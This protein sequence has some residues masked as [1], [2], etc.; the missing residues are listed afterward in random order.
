MKCAYKQ[1][2]TKR[3]QAR[4]EALLTYQEHRARANLFAL[5]LETA[6]DQFGFNGEQLKGLL[7][8]MFEEAGDAFEHYKDESEE[9]YDPNT[10]P[11]LLQGFIN[12]LDALEVDVRKI[13][14][15]HK[16]PT[17]DMK[18]WS[19]SRKATYAGRMEILA[20]RE[21]SYKAYM[22][23][24]MLFLYHEYEY[25]GEKLSAYYNAVLDRYYEIWSAYVVCNDGWDRNLTYLV[26]SPLARLEKI[27]IDLVGATDTDKAKKG[28]ENNEL[29]DGEKS[30]K[31]S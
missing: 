27:G 1:E 17:P 22:Y 25:E 12:Q 7:D 16:F 14:K 30:E 11:F 24:F 10:V 15:S 20:D 4:D 2:I 23:A 19:I 21:V 26:N 6:Q 29:V 28:E 13:E 18:Y 5:A 31:E 9:E 8:G 3:K